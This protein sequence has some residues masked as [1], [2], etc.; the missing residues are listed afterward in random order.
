MIDLHSHT[1]FSDGSSSPEELLALA[2]EVGLSALGITDHD[3]FTGYDHALLLPKPAGLEL[4]CGIEV[5]TRAAGQSVHLLGYFLN[6]EPGVAFR[7]WVHEGQLQRR[8]RNVRLVK[9]LQS[10]GFRIELEEVE[11][12]GRRMTGRPHF[13]RVLMQKGYARSYEEAFD[14]YLGE[15][16][17]AFVRHDGPPIEEAIEQINQAGGVS[18]LAHPVRVRVASVE[19]LIGGLADKGLRAVEVQ[20]SD[21]SALVQTE[22]RQIADKYGLAV[23]GGSDFHGTVKPHVRLGGAKVED[24]VLERLRERFGAGRAT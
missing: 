20:H 24:W 13:A 21:H 15:D 23:T 10:L 4:I 6:G 18:S 7:R 14:R 12:V 16:G 3:D 22:Y 5:T 2:G 1:Y 19:K 17:V 9:K 8:D 11:A